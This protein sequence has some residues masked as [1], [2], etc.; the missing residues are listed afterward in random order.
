MQAL[1]ISHGFA[2]YVERSGLPIWACAILPEHV[3]LVVARFRLDIEQIIIQLK[4]EATQQLIKENLHPFGDRLDHHGRPPKC[5]ARGEWSVFLENAED[6]QRSI[7]YVEQNPV[8]EGKKPQRWPF[9]CPYDPTRF[10]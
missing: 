9:V 6:I 1:A 7:T 2:N 8:K 5:W 10:V 3:H 4:G